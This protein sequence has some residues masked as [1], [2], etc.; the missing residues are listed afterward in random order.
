MQTQI[1]GAFAVQLKKA[2]ATVTVDFD[3]MP[4]ASK[5]HVVA[6]G[7]RQILNDAMAS[8]KTKAEAEGMWAKRLDNLMNGTLRA[9]PQREGNP[10]RARAM[11][12]AIAKVIKS[13]K[14]IE[15]AQKE[16]I[17][18][19]DK[20]AQSAA[21]DNAKRLIEAEGNPFI[22]QAEIDV[23]AAKALEVDDLELDFGEE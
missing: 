2:E 20:R 5:D 21:R 9:S 1:T 18:V 16:G 13:A 15:W 3:K 11:E 8:A 12:L 4:Q 10:V 22:A 17:K 14:F 19:S 7:I 23:A 6:Y